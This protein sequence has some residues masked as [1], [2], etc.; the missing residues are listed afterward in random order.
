MVGLR[1]LAR[2][3]PEVRFYG[4]SHDRPDECSDLARKI[5]ADGRGQLGFPLLADTRA[6]VV[7]RYR[8]RDPEYKNGIPHPTV[9]VLDQNGKIR[10]MKIESD[11]RQRPTNEEVA[12]AIDAFE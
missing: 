5:A 12:A 1:D 3:Y 7:D 6:V 11:Y 8:L 9:I 2:A 4:I 10:W